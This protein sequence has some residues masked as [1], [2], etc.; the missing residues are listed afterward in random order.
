MLH[1]QFQGI[2]LQKSD[3]E[4]EEKL[5]NLSNEYIW[6]LFRFLAGHWPHIRSSG[7]T[8]KHR[9][10]TNGHADWLC[11][12]RHEDRTWQVESEITFSTFHF[13]GLSSTHRSEFFFWDC[14]RLGQV[15]SSPDLECSSV[16]C[17]G[18]CYILAS[19]SKYKEGTNSEKY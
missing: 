3:L 10:K 11:A 5:A 16:V 6:L 9:G 1:W 8:V 2:N 14:L 7:N 13:S 4:Q 15:C 18:T 19:D 17:S 12:A